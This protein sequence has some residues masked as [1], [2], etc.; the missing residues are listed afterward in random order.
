VNLDAENR[1]AFVADLGLDKVLIYKFDSTAGKITPNTPAAVEV[2]PGAGPRHFAFHPNGKLAFVINELSQTVTAF[3]YDSEKGVLTETD[4]QSTV[5]EPVPGNSTAEVVVHPSGKWVY[6]SNRGH[7]SIAIFGVNADTG[8][9]TPL[10]HQKTGGKTPR[11]FALDP[12]GTFLLAENQGSGTIVV[13]RVDCGA[14]TPLLD[15]LDVRPAVTNLGAP[16][17]RRA[18]AIAAHPTNSR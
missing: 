15:F 8:K 14:L 7:D 9:L 2:K 17:L 16:A 5:P 3:R 13:F 6:G 1:F 11:N 4:T 12:T 18:S 10:G